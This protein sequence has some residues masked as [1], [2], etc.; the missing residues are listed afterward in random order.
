MS[1]FVVGLTGGIGSGKSTVAD[2][3]VRLGAALVDTDR[4]AHELTAA[5][6]AA[7]PALRAAFGP[8]ILTPDGALDRTAMRQLAFA[9]PAAKATLEGIL[10]PMIRQLA[11]ERCRVADAPYVILAVPLLIESAHWQERC[12][13]VLT[14]DCPETLQIARVMARSGLSAAEV[15][16]I[17]QNQASR[18]ERRAASHDII[19]NENGV[20]DLWPQIEKLHRCYCALAAR[21]AQAKC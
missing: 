9:D 12:D 21:K 17:M 3:F 6:G 8:G 5:G 4:I 11:D 2:A 16:K 15:G 10:H 19:N 13:R 1:P 7:M 18:A 20:A 14:V